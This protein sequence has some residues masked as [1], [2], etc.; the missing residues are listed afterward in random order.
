MGFLGV[1]KGSNHFLYGL[2]VDGED[3]WK[4]PGHRISKGLGWDLEGFAEER[5]VTGQVAVSGRIRKTVNG[6]VAVKKGV[7]RVRQ[8]PVPVPGPKSG[9]KI[10]WAWFGGLGEGQLLP[11]GLSTL[12]CPL[13]R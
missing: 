8:W 7:T 10:I 12:P 6:W 11:V 4:G 1:K 2:T 9:W 13:T 5:V 3:S